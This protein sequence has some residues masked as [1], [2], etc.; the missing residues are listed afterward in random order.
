MQRHRM[1]LLAVVSIV[2][3][4]P[5]TVR[6]QERGIDVRAHAGHTVGLDDSPPYAWVGGG[7]VTVSTS[8]P[9]RFGLEFSYAH[10]FGPYSDYESRA[11]LFTGLWEYEFNRGGRVNPYAVAGVGMTLYQDLLPSV[12]HYFDHSAPELAWET[13]KS[14]IY[15]RG[16]A[17]SG[18]PLIRL[19]RSRT[20]EDAPPCRPFPPRTAHTTAPASSHEVLDPNV[21]PP[22]SLPSLS[23]RFVKTAANHYTGPEL[24]LDWKR[25]PVRGTGF[26][27]SGQRP[28]CGSFNDRPGA[29]TPAGT[30]R[31]RRNACGTCASRPRSAGRPG[32]LPGGPSRPGRSWARRARAGAR[33][34]S[35][36]RC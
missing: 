3:A 21:Q 22:P 28:T 11:L 27:I 30:H 34:S 36:G 32:R 9:T 35:S 8:T 33:R 12:E 2:A 18:P 6:G 29:V 16:G 15:G 25:R 10:M 1:A 24:E 26:P 19:L 13:Q 17:R 14:R 31:G 7:A 23:F 5:P 20:C 4:F